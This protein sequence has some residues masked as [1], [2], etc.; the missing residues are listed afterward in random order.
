MR[1]PN[2][3]H[4]FGESKVKWYNL[5]CKPKHKGGHSGDK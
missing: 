1:F 2:T 5:I 3:F 4:A